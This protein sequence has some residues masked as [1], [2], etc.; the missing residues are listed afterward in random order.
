MIS[1]TCT[2]CNAKLTIDDAFAGGVCRCQHCG[3][4]QTV[5]SKTRAAAPAAPQPAPVVKA[6]YQ[7]QGRHP[8]SSGTG[9]DDLADAVAS[10]GLAGSGLGSRRNT[11][12]AVAPQT[13]PQATESSPD[14]Q[15]SRR[16]NWLPIMLIG[17]GALVVLLGIL[18]TIALLHGPTGGSAGTGG[19]ADT[20]SGPSF[21]GVPV[22][23]DSVIFLLDRGGSLT[24]LFDTLKATTYKSISALGPD[25]RFQVILCDNDAGPAEFPPDGM[26]TATAGAVADCRRDFQDVVATGSSHLAGPMK[27]ALDRHPGLIVVATGKMELEDDDAAAIRSAVGK[28]IPIDCVQ[29]NSPAPSAVLQEVSKTTGGYFKM[30]TA[31]ELRSFSQ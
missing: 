21:C 7:K 8:A 6:L 29:I 11:R 5:P 20:V 4:I 22:Q 13:T 26:R 30:V 9:L 23:A 1:I 2:N 12:A 14:E 18:L 15:P 25:R 3:T 31:A 28:G 19:S 27:E 16:R 10:S 24:D 17:L